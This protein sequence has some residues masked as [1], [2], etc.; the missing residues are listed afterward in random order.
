E[1]AAAG[2]VVEDEE[3][4]D[5]GDVATEEAAAEEATAEAEEADSPEPGEGT[6]PD[7]GGASSTP[8]S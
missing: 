4:E 2:T 3:P 1:A 5:T 8:E 7:A 6:A